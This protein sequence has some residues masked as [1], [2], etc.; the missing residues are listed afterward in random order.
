MKRF[1]DNV[2][3]QVIEEKL[4]LAL[5][6]ILSPVSVFVMQPELLTRIAGESQQSRVQREELMKKIDVLEKGSVTCNR[7]VHLRQFD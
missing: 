1:I 2:A 4:L 7:F 3:V 6:D 5:A